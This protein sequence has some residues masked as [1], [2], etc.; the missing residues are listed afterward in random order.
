MNWQQPSPATD[1]AVIPTQLEMLSVNGLREL[2]QRIEEA[3]KEANAR[4]RV[5]GV[6][7]TMVQHANSNWEVEQILH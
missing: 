6:V 2:L 3:R 1:Y 7:A 4:L 5:A